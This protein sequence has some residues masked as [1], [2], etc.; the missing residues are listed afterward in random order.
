MDDRRVSGGFAGGVCGYVYRDWG[1]V[2]IQKMYERVSDTLAAQTA[3]K[4]RIVCRF[5]AGRLVCGT[6]SKHKMAR[7]CVYR[8]FWRIKRVGI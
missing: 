5:R 7:A 2:M 3:G 8:K 4:P 6:A 1:M